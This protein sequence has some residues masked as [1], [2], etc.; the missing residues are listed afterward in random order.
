[1]KLFTLVFLLLFATKSSLVSTEE[2]AQLKNAR[3]I[4][5]VRLAELEQERLGSGFLCAATLINSWYV[6]TAATCVSQF[7]APQLQ[8]VLGVTDLSSRNTNAITRRIRRMFF[9]PEFDRNNEYYGNLVALQ[10]QHS[11]RDTTSRWSIFQGYNRFR[12]L[13]VQPIQVS[14]SNPN[15]GTACTLFKWDMSRNSNLFKAN[16]EIFDDFCRNSSSTLCAGD[17]NN[18]TALC[19]NLGSSLICDNTFSG[20]AISDSS[21]YF[22][23]TSYYRDWILKVSFADSLRNTNINHLLLFALLLVKFVDKFIYS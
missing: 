16:F 23:S 1:M 5:S 17:I 14:K 22:E 20:F 4:A 15:Q 8:I 12:N 19:S 13:H 3:F 21:C 9:Y 2:E 7:L 18:G 10:M 6:V 11:I